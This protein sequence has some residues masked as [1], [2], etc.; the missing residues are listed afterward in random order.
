MFRWINKQLGICKSFEI[1][2]VTIRIS[3]NEYHHWINCQTYAWFTLT[4]QSMGGNEYMANPVTRLDFHFFEARNDPFKVQFSGL[5]FYILSK[6][7]IT[8]RDMQLR[9]LKWKP[10]NALKKT[11]QYT[12]WYKMLFTY[13]FLWLERAI[14]QCSD[15]N[16]SHMTKNY[17]TVWILFKSEI[18]E[19]IILKQLHVH[20]N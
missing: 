19:I 16:M 14:N 8:C 17:C 15:E 9:S 2:A 11:I 20:D 7:L 6:T 5:H 1:Y 4:Q 3:M 10:Y 12:S 18:A 13:Q